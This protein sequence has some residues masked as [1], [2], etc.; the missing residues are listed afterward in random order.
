MHPDG[1]I[2]W[3][4]AHGR[5]YPGGA[6]LSE[7]LMGVS[8]DVTQRKLTELQLSESRTLLYALV[9]STSDMIWSVDS[10][11]F[12]LLTFNRS[13]SE[14]FLRQRGIALRPACAR[15]SLPGRAVRKGVA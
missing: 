13:L 10:E 8:N 6:G 7:R 5:P 9:D 3:I 2:R 12:G 14:Y 4:V 1:K 15:G 11:R